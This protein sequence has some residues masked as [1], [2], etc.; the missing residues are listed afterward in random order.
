[1]GLIIARMHTECHYVRECNNHIFPSSHLGISNNQTT[2]RQRAHLLFLVGLVSLI[3]PIEYREFDSNWRMNNFFNIIMTRRDLDATD[4]I[5]WDFIS[6][7]LMHLRLIV[8]SDPKSTSIFIT[9]T[10]LPSSRFGRTLL[11]VDRIFISADRVMSFHFL[12]KY[13][14][15]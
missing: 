8:R 1:M 10:W 14:I 3:S 9:K 11:S 15:L 6:G 12:A 7:H 2:E 5:L 13:D 4:R